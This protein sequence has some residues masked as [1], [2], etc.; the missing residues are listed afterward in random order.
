MAFP[1]ERQ[2]FYPAMLRIHALSCG[3][4]EFDRSLFFPAEAPGTLM[5]APVGSYL[6][7]HPKGK[8]VFDT[9]I[10]CD[11]LADP[12]GRLGKRVASLFRIRSGADENVV[13]Q[14]ATLGIK[15]DDMRTVVNSHF[16]FDHCGCNASFPHARFLVQRAELAIARAERNRYN[17]RDW[18]HPLEYVEL[19]GEH[20]VFGDGTVVALPTPGHTA[21]HQ[22][23]WIRE[24]G[25][26]F[27]LTS[28][29]CYTREH[30]EKTILPSNAYDAAEMGRSLEVLR[31]MKEKRGVELLYGHD[32]AQ[33]AELPRAPRSL[34]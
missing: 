1:P 29:A 18:D 16:H 28:D 6:V 9:G 26:Q 20:D 31:A 4:L 25:R 24:G 3:A 13:A 22:S 21:G 34:L 19:D 23:L 7:V 11:A 2:V 10:S 17:A 12:A 32:A 33:W 15:P 5:V 8:L 27:V 14:L 30:L